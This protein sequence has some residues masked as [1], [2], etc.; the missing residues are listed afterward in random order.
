MLRLPHEIAYLFEEWL[1][2][3][4]PERASKVMNIM[5]SMHE[6]NAYQS[7]FGLRQRGSGPYAKLIARRFKLA[8]E[9]FELTKP[10]TELRT[11][12]FRPPRPDGYKQ[13]D[14]F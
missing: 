4:Y 9:R 7:E 2:A 8:S 5:K 13:M 1:T 12:L 14:L 11:D 3:N 6:G 10:K